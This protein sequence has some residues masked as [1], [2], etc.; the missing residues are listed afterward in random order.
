MNTNQTKIFDRT[1]VAM[2]IG[3][4]IALFIIIFLGAFSVKQAGTIDRQRVDITN[5][6]ESIRI[7]DSIIRSA[8]TVDIKKDSIINTM[9]D[10]WGAVSES[11][12]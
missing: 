10:R 12:E 1:I 7:K 4:F 5:L 9:P 8:E 6:T 3:G 11:V 2:S